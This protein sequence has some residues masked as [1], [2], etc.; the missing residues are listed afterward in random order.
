MSG[1]TVNPLLDWTILP[2]FDQIKIQHF[3]PAVESL[4]EQSEKALSEIEA[5]DPTSWNWDRLMIPIE[6]VDDGFDRVWGVISHLHS[7]KNSQELRDVYDPLLAKVVAFSNRMG[8]SKPIYEAYRALREGREWSDYSDARKRI[9]E[10][11]VREAELN[12]VGLNELD[13][14]R[15]NEI[16]QRQAELS[17][18]YSNNVL[19]Y[20]KAYRL[21]LESR[22]DVLG[23]P[24]TLLELAADEAR[25]DGE[26]GA[27]DKDGPWV[28][29]LEIPSFMPFMQHS[30]NR[31]LRE[32]LYRA[33]VTRASSGD[34][35]N[36]ILIDEILSLRRE[37]AN[38][39]GYE[40][41]ADLSLSRKMAPDVDSVEQLLTELMVAARPGAE[42]DLEDLRD[43]AREAAAPEAADFRQWDSAYW[44]ERL[45]ESRYEIRDEELRPYFPLPRVLH[46]LFELTERL[47]DIKVQKADDEAPIWHEDVQFFK[48]SKVD[49]T[50]IASF[51]L[52]A[53]TRSGEKRGG[54]WMNA[55]VGRSS[56]LAPPGEQVRLP[57]AYL[58]CNQ[59]KPVGGKPSLMTFMEVETLFHEFGH[60]LQ[61]MLTTVDEGLASGLSNIE[62]DAV[63]LASHFM[64]N[65]CF[66]PETLKGLT[67]HFETGDA[68]PDETIERIRA[69]RTFREGSNT[70]R[71]VNFGLFDMEIHH[72]FIP[73]EK[74]SPLE[75]QERI[76]RETMILPPVP[77]DRFLCSFTHIFA[78]GYSAGYYSYKWSEVLSADAFSAFEEAGLEDEEAMKDL[79]IRYRNTILALGGSV[80][81][82]EVFKSFRGREPSTEALLRQGGLT[83]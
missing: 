70:L 30:K 69:T 38:L 46:G 12:G 60:G 77:E 8:Q 54:A 50:P 20:T 52:D 79:G 80:H 76:D 83:P 27:T 59:S 39:L 57:V 65:W 33:Y 26:D 1:V 34:Y 42:R 73:G 43:L 17:T 72:R 48:V 41:Y 35:D 56:V 31:D 62:W 82:M 75:L 45:R 40:N 68:L 44:S 14:D 9:I 36:T 25:Q 22:D 53:Y 67:S 81:P 5:G 11:S 61:H 49:G 13:R 24:D 37:K 47:F 3:E 66:H 32:K 6:R 51:Y 7:V 18:A 19:D 28:I 15:F 4:I 10:S 78:G 16:S 55:C 71:Q 29:T 63:E 64:E 2:P 23:L 74:E 58:M 21:K